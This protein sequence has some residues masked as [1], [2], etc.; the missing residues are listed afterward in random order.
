MAFAAV[1]EL[2]QGRTR[3]LRSRRA[4]EQRQRQC[5]TLLD[6]RARLKSEKVVRAENPETPVNRGVPGFSV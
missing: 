2:S 6:L 5:E 1:F 4:A 3:E